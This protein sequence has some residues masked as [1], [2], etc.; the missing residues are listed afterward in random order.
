MISHQR[1]A[2]G[3]D[4]IRLALADWRQ[5]M[6]DA[7]IA[8]VLVARAELVLAEVFNN[9]DKHGCAGLIG[10]WIVLNTRLSA[11]GLHLTVL[12]N[13]VAPP[14]HLLDPVLAA[15]VPLQG[16]PLAAIPEGG[17]GW[18]LIRQLARDITMDHSLGCNR[19]RLRV[20]SGDADG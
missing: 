12:D 8:P 2:P 11:D 6:A 4:A 19:L 18:F 20:P 9:I 5:K 17:Y 13:G 7:G 15:P 10:G 16:L 3:P 14:A 1:F